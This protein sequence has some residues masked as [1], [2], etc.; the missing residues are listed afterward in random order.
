MTLDALA[1]LDTLSTVTTLQDNAQPIEVWLSQPNIQVTCRI[2]FSDETAIE[3]QVTSLSMRGAQREVT[4]WLI[5]Q[6]YEPAGRWSAED[7]AARETMR[8]FR[9]PV[10]QRPLAPPLTIRRP[11]T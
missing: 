5:A 8:H 1:A 10:L 11:L 6:G 7:K 9:R 3:M 4:S 2:V